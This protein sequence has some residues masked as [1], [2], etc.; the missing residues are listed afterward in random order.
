MAEGWA[1]FLHGDRFDVWS[2]GV[3]KHGLD[4]LAVKVMKEAG[5]DISTHHSKLVDELTDVKFD[6]VITV[7][8]DANEN[9]PIFREPTKVL[10]HGFKDPPSSCG[11][12]MK[13]EEQLDCY[14]EVCEDIRQFVSTL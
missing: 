1:R 5:V 13:H 8:G 9:C 7:C 11:K 14:R 12:Q 2:A 4:P 10:H 6:L 3:E